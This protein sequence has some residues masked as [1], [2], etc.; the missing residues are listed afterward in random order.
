MLDS[1]S[2]YQYQADVEIFI[3]RKHMSW[4]GKTAFDFAFRHNTQ[5]KAETRIE[6]GARK[7]Y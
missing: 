6:I 2:Q 7:D 5:R 3:V 4:G 1:A